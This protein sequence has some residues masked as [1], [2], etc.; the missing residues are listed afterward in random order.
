MISLKKP[1]TFPVSTYLFQ[2]ELAHVMTESLQ[3]GKSI[4]FT[5]STRHLQVFFSIIQRKI[6]LGFIN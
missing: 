2:D 6:A 4:F 5:K 1:V 3:I